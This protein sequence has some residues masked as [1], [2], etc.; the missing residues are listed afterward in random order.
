MYESLFDTLVTTHLKCVQCNL[1]KKIENQ[2]LL[3]SLY[4]SSLKNSKIIFF[5]LENELIFSNHRRFINC[6]FI[7]QCFEVYCW[8]KS[9]LHHENNLNK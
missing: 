4:F 7:C 6:T 8:D 5:N 3:A 2:I 1:K 9:G